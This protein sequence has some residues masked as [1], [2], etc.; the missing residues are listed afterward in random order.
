[1]T[2]VIFNKESGLLNC[3]DNQPSSLRGRVSIPSIVSPAVDIGSKMSLP[4]MMHFRSRIGSRATHHSPLCAATLA[5]PLVILAK[6][7]M[8]VMLMEVTLGGAE[9]TEFAL[10]ILI[11]GQR[12]RPHTTMIHHI[13]IDVA[14]CVR[15]F[16]RAAAT[17]IA[18]LDLSSY[19]CLGSYPVASITVHLALHRTNI[20]ASVVQVQTGLWPW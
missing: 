16:C 12:G 3:A 15:R 8:D 19:P 14:G 4:G 7:S 13:A 17:T 1:M 11:S 18:A 20:I 10:R 5:R 9:C 2:V 6:M